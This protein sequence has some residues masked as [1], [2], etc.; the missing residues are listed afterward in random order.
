MEELNTLIGAPAGTTYPEHILALKDAFKAAVANPEFV[1]DSKRVEKAKDA[2]KMP[3]EE[4][5]VRAQ[6]KS[7]AEKKLRSDAA[8]RA[9]DTGEYVAPTQDEI[10]QHIE[11]GVKAWRAK[12]KKQLS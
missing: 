3:D 9:E 11:R 12:H 7:H 10:N 2:F 5:R 8:I 1:K 4:A 6:L